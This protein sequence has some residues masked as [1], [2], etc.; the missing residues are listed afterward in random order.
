MQENDLRQGF[1]DIAYNFVISEFGVIE[2]RGWDDEAESLIDLEGGGSRFLNL[3]AIGFLSTSYPDTTT[4]KPVELNQKALNEI[5]E[6]KTSKEIAERLIQDGI[7]IR[8]F[9]R[10]LKKI[11]YAPLCQENDE[12]E[13][14]T[15]N[16]TDET[17][18]TARNHV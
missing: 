18:V 8:K 2:G 5:D 14:S 1:H 15:I 4:Y 13:T 16:S 6:Y 11:C 3:A 7:I 17:T 12:N 9:S 10:K